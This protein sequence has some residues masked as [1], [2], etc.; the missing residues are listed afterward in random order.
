MNDMKES[1]ADAKAGG[2]KPGKDPEACGYQKGML[3]GCA[4]LAV[5]YVPMQ[6]GAEPAYESDVA[7]SR[8]TLFPG[9][10]LPFKNV[11]NGATVETPLTELMAI[12][13]VCSE[14]ELYLDTHQNDK[15]AFAAY[16]GFLKLADEGRRRYVSIYGPIT[17]AD[18][19]GMG[20]FTWV[21][22]PWPWD[23]YEGGKK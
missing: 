4:P 7:L 6:Q 11:V 15:E 16:Q 13:F 2:K 9:L 5:S 12:D 22:N 1:A 8:G 18:L 10:D 14:L 19:Q 21:N 20:S 3:P 17:R 23:Y